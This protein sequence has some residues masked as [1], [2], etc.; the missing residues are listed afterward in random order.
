MP[1]ILVVDDALFMRVAVSKMFEGWGYTVIGQAS[2]GK[3]A[4]EKYD[5]LR[6]D[7]VTMDVTMPI[8][9]GLDAVKAITDMHPQANVIIVTAM[10]QPR[11]RAKAL[12][13]GA[14]G[15]LTKPFEPEHLRSLVDDI[16]NSNE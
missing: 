6:P 13:N 2:N 15:F 1:K 5:E 14:K 4:V 9:S 16:I 12:A 7:I 8:M 11:L 10:G 3:E